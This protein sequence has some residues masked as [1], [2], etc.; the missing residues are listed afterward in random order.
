MNDQLIKNNFLI[1]KNIIDRDFAIDLGSEFKNDCEDADFAGDRQAR[2]SHSVYNY[3]RAL[4]LLCEL[5]SEV[6]N[7]IGEPVLPTYTYGRIYK[8]GSTLEK[9]TDRSACEISL[10]L[11]LDGD[12]PWPIWV[13]NVHGKSNCIYLEPGDAMLYLGCVAPHWRDEFEGEWYS[14]FFLH[15][16]RSNGPCRECYFDKVK[17]KNEDIIRDALYDEVK[18]DKEIPRQLINKYV[19][20]LVLNENDLDNSNFNSITALNSETEMSNNSILDILEQKRNKLKSKKES[21]V[22][23]KQIDVESAFIRFD[24]KNVSNNSEFPSLDTFIEVYKGGVPSKL[25]DSILNEYITQDLWNHAMTAGG[26]DE[27]A[28]NCDVIGISERGILDQNHDYRM[29]LD[30]ELYDC[31]HK[32]LD[33]YEDK[34]GGDQGLSIEKDTGYELLRYREGQF[35]IQHTDHFAEQPRTLSCTI[36]LNDDYEGG[37]FAFFDRKIKMKLNKGD[38]LMFPSGFMYPHEVMPVIKGNRY[39][40]ITW[41]V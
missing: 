31:V 3:K 40:I 28:R 32:A 4:E 5:N 10:T 25:C 33:M 26:R 36:C 23:E 24:D 12:E 30:S 27:Q 11:H 29:K 7:V 38:I 14:Q 1:L 39:N 16:V 17:T 21:P 35:Y 2:N 34:H 18:N 22:I 13:E 41:L 8:N 15:Y 9:H 37:E 19:S 20:G 6:S